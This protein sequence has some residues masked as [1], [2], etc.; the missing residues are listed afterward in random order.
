MQLGSSS[1]PNYYR[2]NPNP[3][4]DSCQARGTE[5]RYNRGMIN[6]DEPQ[7]GGRP[8]DNS[9]GLHSEW[10]RCRLVPDS[11][12]SGWLITPFLPAFSVCSFDYR[13]Q[14]TSVEYQL[15]GESEWRPAAILEDTGEHAGVAV[16]L[17][18]LHI[19][20]LQ[21][22]GRVQFKITLTKPPAEDE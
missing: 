19:H 9:P 22:F 4:D 18:R 6:G 5:G 13:D 12:T 11:V 3:N 10:E 1:D 7:L 14:L 21:R 2:S 15:E 20:D 16:P 17:D 8:V